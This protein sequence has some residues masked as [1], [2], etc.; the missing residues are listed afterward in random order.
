MKKTI[1]AALSGLLLLISSGAFAQ[2]PSLTPEQEQA[3][4]RADILLDAASEK[5]RGDV[6][7][8]ARLY[9]EWSGQ[10]AAGLAELIKSQYQAEID[11]LN[12]F[13]SE[14]PKVLSPPSANLVPGAPSTKQGAV[15]LS[16]F[17]FVARRGDVATI[18][19]TA[20]D[21]VGEDAQ[22]AVLSALSTE[23]SKAFP[24]LRES[25]LLLA[26]PSPQFIDG[27]PLAPARLVVSFSVF[28][29][30]QAPAIREQLRAFVERESLIGHGL[31]SS[32]QKTLEADP[33]GSRRQNMIFDRFLSAYRILPP[34]QLFA[35]VY[36]QFPSIHHAPAPSRREL[37]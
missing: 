17:A 23:L 9:N 33:R 28:P 10:A 36:H 31:L 22:R 20:K 27:R 14:A 11:G 5:W 4:A 30:P 7:A 25:A 8:A 3:E 6:L 35:S 13:P 24:T 16:S 1:F 21:I 37:P 2:Q 15:A 29:E 32:L 18:L 26:I 19:I 34:E 12:S